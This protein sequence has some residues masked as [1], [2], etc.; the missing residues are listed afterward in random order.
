MTNHHIIKFI[1]INIMKKSALDGH[2][3]VKT[4]GHRW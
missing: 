3:Y 1:G 2:K 4:H